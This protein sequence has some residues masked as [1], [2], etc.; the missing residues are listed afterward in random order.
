M[1]TV[2]ACLTLLA[3][4]CGKDDKKEV[5][6]IYS[7]A[8][9][10][11]PEVLAEFEKSTTAVSTMMSIQTTKNCWPNYRPAAPSSILSSLRTTW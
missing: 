5:L 2:A 7:W 4:G 9:Y 8:D 11:D 3:V 6:N 1:L 10:Y